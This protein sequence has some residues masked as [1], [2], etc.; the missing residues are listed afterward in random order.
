[1]YDSSQ[2]TNS[3]DIRSNSGFAAKRDTK[4]YYKRVEVYL[5]ATNKISS[6]DEN[7]Q[8]IGIESL[9]NLLEKYVNP[10]LKDLPFRILYQNLCI[11]AFENENTQINTNSMGCLGFLSTLNAESFPIDYI[12]NPNVIDVIKQ[13]VYSQ[14]GEMVNASL[15]LLSYIIMYSSDTRELLLNDEGLIN[16]CTG[17]TEQYQV[18][19]FCYSVVFPNGLINEEYIEVMSPIIYKHL[20][21]PLEYNAQKA[22]EY[23]YQLHKL[24]VFEI[25]YVAISRSLVH[26][27]NTKNTKIIE[28]S[29]RF[30]GILSNP[31]AELITSMIKVASRSIISAKLGY[32]YL[33]SLLPHMTE[34]LIQ[35]FYQSLIK[36]MNSCSHSVGNYVIIA[37]V[38]IIE[39][40]GELDFTIIPLLIKYLSSKKK[41]TIQLCINGLVSLAQK[42]EISGKTLDFLSQIEEYKEDFEM[43]SMSD[44]PHVAELSN[45]FL[46][47]LN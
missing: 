29:L 12:L 21:S 22:I 5:Q 27:L 37:L 11:Y 7:S 6:Q 16:Y 4:N 38:D 10:A 43:L 3:S 15:L 39:F 20:L 25:D 46:E 40:V 30:T 34:D 31:D 44:N 26:L 9:Y 33:R 1:M 19:P 18:A 45:S 8:V 2:E 32:K 14:N 36:S 28:F 35:F 13:R 41:L 47:K 42:A 24:K 23:L 17:L